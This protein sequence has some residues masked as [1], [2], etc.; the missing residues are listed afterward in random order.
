MGLQ[1]VS[2][3]IS[4]IRVVKHPMRRVIC[5]LAAALLADGSSLNSTAKSYS[6]GG[7]RSY[8]SHSSS[9]SSSHRSSSGGSR[10]VSSSGTRTSSSGGS[11]SSGGTSPRSSSVSSS[12]SGSR[13]ASPAGSGGGGRVTTASQKSSSSKSSSP[14]FSSSGGKSY[15]SSSTASDSSRHSYTSGKSYTSGAG[16]TFTSTATADRRPKPTPAARTSQS[17]P[18]STGFTFDQAAARVRKEEAS[19]VKFTQYKESQL[20]PP[21]AP[22]EA[23]P[24]VALSDTVRPVPDTTSYRVQPPPLPVPAGGSDRPAVYVPAPDTLASRPER[25]YHVFNPYASRPVV[26]YRDRYDSLFWWWLLDRSLEDRARWAYHHHYEMDPA[27]YQALVTSDQQ[28]E[29]RVAQLEAEQAPRDTAY[30]P[31]GID[32]DLMYS[33]HYV[34]RAYSNR[35]TASGV[36]AFWLLAVPT[37]LAVTAFFI[38]LIWFKRWQ[39]AS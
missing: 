35:P 12:S 6:S 4:L 1:P 27:R 18:G 34:Q 26:I 14:S 21:V 16:H 20:P 31:D 19:K 38:W 36:F 37:A 29:A 9:S 2:G 15:S 28:L 30:V 7:G 5:L 24:P 32:R 10:S 25:S 11:R 13:S 22:T 8:S 17:E 3:M 23:P 39:T 33:D